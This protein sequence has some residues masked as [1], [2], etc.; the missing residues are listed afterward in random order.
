M[1]YYNTVSTTVEACCGD[2]DNTPQV[3]PIKL[4]K[5]RENR[6][7][8]LPDLR[9]PIPDEI[10][11]TD[12][13]QKL[14]TKY[15]LVPFAGLD[16]G[17]GHTL[18]LWYQMLAKLSPT[19]GA[20]IEK[21]T[22]YTVGG[23]PTVEMRLDPDFNTGEERA[24]MATAAKV[25]YRDRL[26][27][28]VTWGGLTMREAAKK[29]ARLYK[30]YGNC[31]ADMS[32]S[33]INGQ[34]RV[35]IKVRDIT[36]CIYQLSEANEPKRV[37]ISPVW[38]AQYIEKNP[39]A[40]VPIYPN[41]VQTNGVQ[42]TVFHLK[43][44]GNWYGRPDSEHG[45]LFKYREVQDALY[46]IKQAAANF[47]GQLILEVEENDP[48]SAPVIDDKGA[49]EDGYGSF[50]EQFE[51]NFSQKGEDPKSVVITSRP[52]GAKPMFAFQVAPNTNEGWYQA[53][54]AI[55]ESKII[56]AHGLT[57][58]FMGKDVSNGFSQDAFI[59]DYVMN[60]E[61]TI[62][63]LYN[64]VVGFLN[65]LLN[66]AWTFTGDAQMVQYSVEFESPIKSQVE[67]YKNGEFS[68]G[69]GSGE[70]QPG[71]QGLPN[72]RTVTDNSGG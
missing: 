15:R 34:T 8:R 66:G 62:N 63:S 13:I 43:N 38:T 71:R 28:V 19:H 27:E 23:L 21:M 32:I 4:R 7:T 39:P 14:L 35:D 41:T 40:I 29:I 70:V 5:R 16:I 65:T 68:N 69:T 10:K 11:D 47:V 64:V 48:V 54:D 24:T 61:P 3:P 42:R 17:T 58:R 30:K 44:G 59:S 33:T 37:A 45:D 31:F 55:N 18:L 20:V 46:I 22:T 1:S 60:V 26:N 50:V 6:S 49:Q 56:T 72:R 36:D 52:F 67:R 51:A 2:E 9:N 25:A 57:M 12:E 53:T